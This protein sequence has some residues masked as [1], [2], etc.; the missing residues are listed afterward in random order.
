MAEA[1]TSYK[2]ENDEKFKAAITRARLVTDDLRI[3]LTLISKDFYKSEKAI[4]MLSGP[5][6]YPDF[7]G[8][9]PEE[10]VMVK[11]REVTRRVAAKFRKQQKHGFVYPLMRGT[12]RI[13]K[14]LTEP[15][16]PDSFNQIVNRRTLIIGSEV[17]YLKYHQSDEPRSK[18]PLRK[19]LFIGPES[20]FANSDQQGRVGRWM[21]IMNDFVIKKMKQRYG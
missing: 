18:I 19:L 5:G 16:A 11:G 8:L 3:P 9:N 1:F 7:G 14:S 6:Q 13:E 2:I 10:K 17:P 15:T 21:N 4:F 20:K 12:G